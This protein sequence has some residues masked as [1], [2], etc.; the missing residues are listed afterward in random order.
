MQK[1]PTG[2]DRRAKIIELL[3][4]S[5]APLSGNNLAKTLGVS[6][7]VIV[8][9]MAL[10]R[11]EHNEILST[12]QGYLIEK[13]EETAGVTRIYK[14]KHTDEQTGEELLSI[15]ELGGDVLDVF[16]EHKVYGTISA[17]LNVSSKRDVENFLADLK[18]GVS[19]PLKNI[20]DGYH[21]HTVKARN[22]KILDEIEK[23]L[24]EKGF[25]IETRESAEK[26]EAKDYRKI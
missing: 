11:A 14:V 2:D 3:K 24:K 25:L 23:M 8:T 5:T 7:Q 4:N 19:S 16:V 22:T 18:S 10:L 9:D 13:N 6:R 26:Y 1:K 17:P 21:Y 20:T 15:V 12:A